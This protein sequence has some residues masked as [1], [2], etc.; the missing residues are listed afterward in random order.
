MHITLGT[1]AGMPPPLRHC[2]LEKISFSH[3]MAY[4]SVANYLEGGVDQSQ[5]RPRIGD[6]PAPA[7]R[8]AASLSAFESMRMTSSVRSECCQ[9]YAIELA[10]H[11]CRRR[12]HQFP[13]QRL[14]F[15]HSEILNNKVRKDCCVASPSS[16]ANAQQPAVQCPPRSSLLIG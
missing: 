15:R 14:S 10:G 12:R 16:P 6:S 5:I 1:D 4:V 2:G 3:N 9:F 7:P 13:I 8:R 11:T